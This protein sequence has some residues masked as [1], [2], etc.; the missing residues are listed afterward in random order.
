MA[1]DPANGPSF[2]KAP[3]KMLDGPPIAPERHTAKLDEEAQEESD[4][5]LL[6]DDPGR[7]LKKHG[8]IKEEL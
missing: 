3:V 7:W 6:N 2:T 1:K 5:K 4:S 8:L